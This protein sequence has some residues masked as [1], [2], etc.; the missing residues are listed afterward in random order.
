MASNY[1]PNELKQREAKYHKKG[2]VKQ[3]DVCWKVM[4]SNHGA[5]RIFGHT[6]S[7]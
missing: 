5:G 2:T 4:G 6:K 1:G 7:R 3:E